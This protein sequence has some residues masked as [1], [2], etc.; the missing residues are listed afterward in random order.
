[1]EEHK[2]K[3]NSQ[4]A[5]EQPGMNDTSAVLKRAAQRAVELLGMIPVE[6]QKE[7]PTS[8]G[9]IS[10]QI[11]SDSAALQIVQI[12][13]YLD[14]VMGDDLEGMRAWWHSSN[15]ALGAKPN[16]LARSEQGRVR[17]IDYLAMMASRR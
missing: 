2:G 13:K 4:N 1:M 16:E 5:A 9:S 3:T 14:Q 12:Y 6:S 8:V 7:A 11:G 10:N 15:A 17:I